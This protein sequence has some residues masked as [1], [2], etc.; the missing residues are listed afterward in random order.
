M[1]KPRDIRIADLLLDTQNPR[2]EPSTAQR[3][4]MQKLLDDQQDRIRSLADDIVENGVSPIDLPIVMP[5]KTENGKFI[6]LEGNRR[7]LALKI[8]SNP[9]V[10]GDLTLPGGRRTKL[11][12]LAKQFSA[13]PIKELTCHVVDSRE[14]AQHWL[15]LRHMGESQGAGVVGWGGVA[16]ARFRGEDPALQAIEFVVRSGRLSA[17]DAAL[18]RSM[19]FPITTLRRLLESRDVKNFLGVEVKD[20]K[21]LSGLPAD[22]LIKPLKRIMLDLARGDVTVT[23]IKRKEHQAAYIGKFPSS[24]RPTLGKAASMRPVQDITSADFTGKSGG[25]MRKKTNKPP[26]RPHVVPRADRCPIKNAKT[27]EI[28]YE[29]RALRVD[30][31]P[32]ACAVLLR[33]FLELTTDCYLKHFSISLK[34]PRDKGGHEH[35]KSLAT[36]TIEAI[37]HLVANGAKQSDFQSLRRG[38]NQDHSPLSTTLLNEYVHNEFTKPKARDLRDAWDQAQPFFQQAWEK[39]T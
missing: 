4:E 30:D 35:D 6:V 34:K 10:L 27:N 12:A 33:V 2:T 7:V 13:E 5:S 36:K 18:V 24:D 1:S 9:H 23:D 28:Y 8:L 11:E 38:V 21:L 31:T 37:D 29:L 3:E 39:V 17:E 19:R 14:R 16:T 22:E 26:D 32:H 15:E 25:G 20:K